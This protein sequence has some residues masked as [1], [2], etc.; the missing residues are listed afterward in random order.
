METSDREK[1]ARKL[2]HAFG[3]TQVPVPTG[4]PNNG[5]HFAKIK[6]CWVIIGWK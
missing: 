2:A 4:C 1:R 5:S 3:L 6:I